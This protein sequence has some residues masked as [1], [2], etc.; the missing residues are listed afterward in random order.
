MG[1]AI[2]QFL[3]IAIGIALSP[4]PIVAVV[5]MLAT[6]RARA[7]G[8]AFVAAWIVG[9]AAVGIVV[10]AL[11]GDDAT[12][13]SG[14]PADWVS[15]LKL[16]LGLL[17]LAFG[18]R[19]W[20][21]RPRGGEAGELPKWM[22]A[23]DTF[24]PPKAAGAGLLLSAANPKNLVLAVAGAAAIAQADIPVGQEAGAL[25]IFVAIGTLGVAAPLVLY[26]AL[27]ERSRAVLD[28]LKDWMARNN[29]TIMA[30][31]ALIIGLKLIGDAI[32]G[33]SA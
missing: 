13:D 21:R 17:L 24:T 26:L 23:L 3:P 19:A 11:A 22:R 8:P 30:V 14:A 15:W 32:S 18:V 28:E 1:D 9:L 10:L 33:F 2:G 4:F 6:P 31:L 20:R 29:S 27:G 7:N 25:A 5:L 16:I 12:S